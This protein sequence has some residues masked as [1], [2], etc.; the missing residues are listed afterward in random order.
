VPAPLTL[1][2]ARRLLAEG[3]LSPLELLEAC[4][5]RIAA[6]EPSLRAWITLDLEGARTQA[7]SLDPAGRAAAPL[8]GIPLAVKDVIDV[9]GLPTTAASRI[10]AGNVAA[11]DAPAVARLRA[12]GAVV[13]GK[14]NTQEFAYGAV[15]PPT[16][17]PWD[18]ARIPGGSS[19]GS[20]A[21]VAAGHCPAALGTDTAGSIRIPAALCGVVGLT[22]R[23]GVVPLE[24]VIPLA[25]SFDAVGPIAAT[26]EDTALLWQA[27]SGTPPPEPARTLRIGVAPAAALP[28]LTPGV[29]AAFEEA[30]EALRRAGATVTEATSCPRLSRFDPAR[31]PVHMWE[32][33]Q[34][35]RGRGWWPE[36]ADGYT[37]ETRSSL[38]NAER[39]GPDEKELAEA[40]AACA[41]LSAELRASVEEH[42]ILATPTVP[43]EAPTHE[44]AAER[45]SGTPR[46]PVVMRLTRIPAPVNV[47]GL[48]ALT[49][50]CGSGSGGLPVGLQLIGREETALLAAGRAIEEATGWTPWRPRS[51]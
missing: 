27:L 19:G 48:A 13:L 34:V 35:H 18:P 43:C 38:S 25:P 20:A 39:T 30:L 21:A 46:R 49:V 42:A 32:A 8:W 2:A 10:L 37:D 47:A 26:V 22:P 17:N 28:E 45:R 24:G 23:P 16:T 7:R 41:A 14:T 33:L 40:R 5:E 51:R 6:S 1:A 4:A 31:I 12:A 29:A 50:P 15:T 44:E 11:A 36:H 3:G 9:A